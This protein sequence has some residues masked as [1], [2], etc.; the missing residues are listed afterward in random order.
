MKDKDIYTDFPASRVYKVANMNRQGY[1]M[2]SAG[3]DFYGENQEEKNI[4]PDDISEIEE[5]IEIGEIAI[6]S[7][8]DSNNDVFT[9]N[10]DALDSELDDQ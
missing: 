6:N 4:N 7:V 2:Y 9:S 1:L 8:M 3:E 5:S 10:L